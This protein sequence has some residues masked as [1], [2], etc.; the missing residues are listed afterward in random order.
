MQRLPFHLETGEQA[1][2][3]LP[4]T[5]PGGM[6]VFDYDGD[7]LLDIFFAN[8][9]EL[10]SGQKT[11]K[12]SDRLLRNKGGM[13]FEDVTAQAGL[14]GTQYDFGA[15]AADYDA[16]GHIDLLVSG[17]R[18]VTLYRNKGDGS[19]A[20]VTAATHIDNR[21]RWS[22]SS[23][24]FDMDNDSDLDLFVVNYVK[25]DPA[26]ERECLVAGKPDFCH[27][28]F[29]DAV[30]NALF[31]NNGNGTFTDVSEASG[32]GKHAGKG[33]SA[34]AADF[35]DDGLTD[36][37]VTNDRTFAFQFRNTGSGRFEEVAFDWGVAVPEDGKPVSGMGVDA[38]DYDND[39][40]TD[41]VYT[42]LRDETFPLYRNTGKAFTEMTA[43]SRLSVL[44]RKMS[45]WGVAFA[46]LDNDGWK[47]IAAAC[48][49]ALSPNGG[50][51]PA[52]METP[53]WFRNT[54][55]GRFEPGS[56]WNTAPPAMYRGLIAADL[57]NDGCLDIVLSALNAEA[58]ILRNPCTNGRNWI[59]VD[60]PIIGTKV[61][62]GAQWRQVTSS[63]GYASSY[64]GPLHFGVDK[65]E[66]V[67][68]EAILPGGK[69][70]RTKSPVNRTWIVGKP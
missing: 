11:S 33:M 43:A 42:A 29:Y 34:A 5:V 12:H 17:L 69:R 4:A 58:Q 60:A 27:P 48:S 22:V 36:I 23:I 26:T 46:D 64:M 67:E 14:T 3:P 56:G 24:W 38:Q 55:N 57:D 1:R 63:T 62:V 10:P 40:R 32:I 52:A 20:D 8:G 51:G 35:D 41:L 37:F 65:A 28:R 13:Q 18:G 45:G 49:D 21:G 2:K 19:F 53:A 6:A 44:S 25:W 61:R 59:K 15:S 68:V 31:R 50:R 70:V 16:D 39:G 30:P 9:A 54:G 47:D 7:G 66:I